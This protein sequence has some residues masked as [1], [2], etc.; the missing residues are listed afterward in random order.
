MFA[1]NEENF[2]EILH[3]YEQYISNHQNGY[4]DVEELE[5]IVDYYLWKGRTKESNK[6]VDLGLILHPNSSTL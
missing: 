3:R 1:P 6:V 5:Q 2:E 4:F